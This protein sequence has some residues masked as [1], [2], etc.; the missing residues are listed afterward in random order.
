MLYKRQGKPREGEILLCTVTKI[1]H[2]SIFANLDEYPG[3]SG[4]IHISEVAP[5][6]IRNIRDYVAEGK[7]VVCKLL[8]I[9]ED[10]GHIDLSLRRVNESQRRAKN[11]FIKQEQKAEKIIEFVCKEFKKDV[12]STYQK[13]SSAVFPRFDSLHDVF[14]G[15]VMEEFDLKELGMDKEF[16]LKLGEIVKQRVKPPEVEVSGEISIISHAFDG[17]SIVKDALV[18]AAEKGGPDSE[19]RYL[20]AG[21]F[22]II[23]K[24]SEYKEAEK[25]MDAIIDTATSNA[26][27]NDAEVHFVRTK[28]KA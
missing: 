1:Y 27:K 12:K 5:G 11:E 21:K 10:R 23:I 16:T 28:A 7:K 8:K 6:R 26:E 25:F 19:I 17:V 13:I 4:M 18:K 3:M 20:G 15:Y 22:K 9:H 2:H 24:G 14:F